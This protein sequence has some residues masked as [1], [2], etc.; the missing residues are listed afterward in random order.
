[1]CVDKVEVVDE[2]I[3]MMVDDIVGVG[4][5]VRVHKVLPLEMVCV[6]V[7]GALD[8]VTGCKS[9]SC[10]YCFDCSTEHGIVKYGCVV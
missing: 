4:F 10:K 9:K 8:M 7:E 1:V 2:I 6:L 5:I 3:E